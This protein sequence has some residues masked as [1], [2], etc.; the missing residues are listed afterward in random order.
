MTTLVER[1]DPPDRPAPPD[2]VRTV[3]RRREP[4]AA[5]LP[6]RPLIDG[7]RGVL[8]GITVAYHLDDDGLLPGGWVGVSGFFVLSGFLITSIVLAEQG[9][10]GWV[11]LPRFF[12]RRVRRLGPALL[13]VVAATMVVARALGGVR[14]WPTLRGDGLASLL[15]V[16]NWRFIATDQSYFASFSPSPLRHIWSLAIE[17]QFYVVWPVVLM[18]VVAAIG[19]RWLPVAL[20]GLAL[21]SALWMRVVAGS[22]TDLSRAYYGTD[23]RAQEILIGATL[24]A[25]LLLRARARG[26]TSDGDA[27]AAW[28]GLPVAPIVGAAGLVGFAAVALTLSADDPSTYRNLGITGAALVSAALVYGCVGTDG[29]PL[30]R[31][32]GSPPLRAL[33]A[34]SY[35]L[36][37][38]HWPVIVFL[39]PPRLTWDPLLLDLTRIVVAV[40]VTEAV[41]RFVE[42]PIH[43]RTWV[44]P[45]P[46]LTLALA[47]AAAIVVALVASAPLARDDDTVVAAPTAETGVVTAPPTTAAPP[48]APTTAPVFGPRI[49]VVG[50]SQA[51]V[52]L[53][54]TVPA[55]LGLQVHGAFHA[56]CDILGAR[57]YIGDQPADAADGCETWPDLW[58][59]ALAGETDTVVVALGLRQ[60]FDVDVDGTRVELGTERWERM[61]RTAVERAVGTIRRHTDAPI[62]WLDVPC[63][64]WREGGDAGELTDL[65]RITT[66]NDLLAEVLGEADDDVTVAPYRER[67]CGGPDATEPDDALRPDGAHL[68]VAAAAETWRWLDTVI[69]QA[70]G[71]A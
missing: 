9:Q 8:V 46:R 5:P 58:G 19:R 34:R 66:V 30:A 4:P 62:V 65:D 14:T 43:R 1:P 55:D 36:Y 71:V 16:A 45:R 51:Y 11:S 48:T 15:Y 22:G 33:G 25:V 12:A 52:L 26:G 61:F 23:T 64:R 56:Q 59:Q 42:R 21:A 70:Q 28:G 18:V 39:A 47:T 20:G 60:L 63:F 35:V 32:L 69:R 44:P 50:D 68:T 17:E 37:L 10:N 7:L 29:G 38:V 57:V 41:H 13:V 2:R 31:V 53:D 40:A 54:D 3:R 49:T 67:V 24:A 6:H 27:R